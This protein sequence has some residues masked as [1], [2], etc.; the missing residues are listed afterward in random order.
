M[1]KFEDTSYESLLLAVKLS[2][3]ERSDRVFISSIDD[4]SF[5]LQSGNSFDYELLNVVEEHNFRIQCITHRDSTRSLKI[6]LTEI[7]E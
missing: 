7:D 2:E 1:N 3:F 4:I 5:H 6:W